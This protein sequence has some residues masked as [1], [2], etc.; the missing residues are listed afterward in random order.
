MSSSFQVV[1]APPLT[2]TERF[3]AITVENVQTLVLQSTE[4]GSWM[5]YSEDGLN[6][7]FSRYKL[8][9]FQ[10][11]DGTGDSALVITFP[12]EPFTGTLFFA[13]EGASADSRVHIWAIQ[14]GQGRY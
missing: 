2:S 1:V 3:P 4:K 8:S 6:Q 9:K 5:S 7:P 12:L 10:D 11:A 14:C 13:S